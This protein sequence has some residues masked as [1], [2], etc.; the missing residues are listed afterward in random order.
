MNSITKLHA[1]EIRAHIQ[2]PENCPLPKGCEEQFN[3]V[4]TIAQLL[5]E[6]PNDAAIENVIRHKFS[7]SVS[8]SAIR[9][10]IKLARELFK[11]KFDFDWDF[12][13]AWEIKDQFEL[14]RR[15]K[16]KGDLK[17]W[18]DAKKVLHTLIGERPEGVEN[19]KRAE[20]TVINIQ[21]NKNGSQ[22]TLSLDD[23]R[24]LSDDD[25]EEIFDSADAEVTVE[26]AE[27]IMN[28]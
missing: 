3:Q 6:Y 15:A 21:I 18:N 5:D 8:K 1:D 9:N 26:E 25:I 10:N 17:M 24:Q 19:N 16:E 2:D 4:C 27:I 12:I 28:S 23:A 20:Q 7:Y 22:K 13:R 11:S 14:V